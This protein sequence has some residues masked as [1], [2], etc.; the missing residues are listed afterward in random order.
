M[1]LYTPVSMLYPFKY[2]ILN[3]LEQVLDTLRGILS[4]TYVRNQQI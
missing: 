2:G 1:N 3:A 4:E